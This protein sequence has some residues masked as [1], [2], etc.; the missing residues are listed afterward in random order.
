MFLNAA[1]EFVYVRSYARW[2]EGEG[3]RENWPETVDRY[4]SFLEKERGEQVPS[5]VFRKA[6][7]YMLDFS[8]M[9]S[10]RALWAAGPAAEADNTTMYNCSF[11]AITSIESFQECMYILMCGSG[12]G[13]SVESKYISQLPS[14][15]KLTSEG[16]GTFVVED[17]KR[18]WA[19]SVGKLITVLYQG[20]D[21]T[22][23]YTKIRPCGAKLKTMGGRASGPAP[24][25]ILHNFIRSVFEKAQGRQ[26]TSLE[27]HDIVNQIA[28]VVIVGGVRRSS[29]I[30]LSD[31]E[32]PEMREAKTWPFPLRRNNA[33][34]SAV[35]TEKPPAVEFLKEWSHLAASGTG[36]RG[37]FNLEAVQN[38]APRRR[39]TSLIAGTN[40]CCEITLRNAE[41]CNLSEV[42]IREN[43][44][45]DDLLDKIE[46]ATWLGAI[47]STFTKFP[48]LNPKWRKNCEEERLLGVSLTGQ[49][50]NIGILSKD[51]LKAMKA[52]ALKVAKKASKALGINVAAAITCVKPSGTVSQLVDSSSGLHPRYAPYYIRR[53]RISSTDPLF[54]LLRDQGAPLSPE[55]GQRRK[56]WAKAKKMQEDGHPEY[57]T[58]GGTGEKREGYRD[59][60]SIFD[61]NS[62]WEESKVITWVV[63]FPIKSPKTAV[64]RSDL[65][66]LQQLEHYRLIQEN[67]C[68]HNASC[69]VYVKDH[70]WFEVGNWVYQNWDIINGV[71]FFPYSGAR[72]EQAPYEEITEEQYAK[73]SSNFPTLDYSSLSRYE[74]EDQSLGNKELACVGDKCDI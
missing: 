35:Y 58:T 1:A 27:V 3:R 55:N 49:M 48:Y 73:M 26:L 60:C 11:Q 52:R 8:V 45:L 53:Y 22:M 4:I 69:T 54:R 15:P 23:D 13:F 18:G 16:A 72:Y 51:A 12:Y 29:Q 74:S 68:E 50:D 67:W 37:I 20:R 64:F 31:R 14:V 57:A 59:V 17:S 10:M 30:S 66:A 34:N 5:K 41:F 42:V 56:D 39:N 46:C 71:A 28:E 7:E 33:N 36:E 24:L 43:D 32:D 9:G 25:M 44:D 62:E 6:R 47:Q 21:I 2:V 61:I 40:P 19:D 65:S 70:E 38:T 63:C